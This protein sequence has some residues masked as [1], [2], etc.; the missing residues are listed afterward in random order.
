MNAELP[1]LLRR[2]ASQVTGFGGLDLANKEPMTIVC[3]P[4]ERVALLLNVTVS[5]TTVGNREYPD[6][7]YTNVYA[8]EPVTVVIPFHLP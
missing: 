4:D 3:L 5:V 1:D 2:L 8:E 7:T 6:E